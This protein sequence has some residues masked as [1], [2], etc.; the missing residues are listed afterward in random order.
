M[1]NGTENPLFGSVERRLFRATA[2]LLAIILL[3]ALTGFVIWSL[4][5]TLV[6]FNRL[7]VPLVV[8]GLL[9]LI[10]YPIVDFLEMRLRLPRVVAVSL[11]V[12]LAT[13]GILGILLAIIPTLVR[14]F[15]LFA[16]AAPQIIAG[17]EH[18]LRGQ[19]PGLTKM[20]TDRVEEAGLDDMVAADAEDTRR[21][22]VS[23]VWL[24]IGLSFVP[25]FLFFALLSGR[26][27]RA[28][29]AELL[30]IFSAPTQAR[31]LYFVEVFL[32]L[33]TAFFRGQL[34]IAIIM[35][36]LYGIGFS[37]IGLR[38]G[39]LIGLVLGLL[40]LVPFLGALIG[41]LLA[42]PMAYF[43]PGGGLELLGLAMLVI[44]VVQAIESWLLTPK[45]MADRSGLHPAVVVISIF[46]W[47]TLLGGVVG[48]ILAVPLT[49]FLV[50]V[51]AQMKTQLKR[52]MDADDTYEKLYV[53][54]GVQTDAEALEL[55]ASDDEPKEPAAREA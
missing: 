19:F 34:V 15:A 48:M 31:V 2:V 28:P 45:I 26:R 43:Q 23:Y 40:N 41:L 33:M 38:G 55:E 4:G 5:Q 32:R 51:W 10:L 3:V 42:L 52:T 14:Q 25:L 46:F 44:L 39:L 16:D 53:P 30:S 18:Y 27:L 49:A 35:G 7:V 54:P 24:I 13:A 21:T 29:A 20:V 17:W 12:L 47:G 36:I 11:V 6:F 9:A 8:A 1:N 50:A 22:V 37:L